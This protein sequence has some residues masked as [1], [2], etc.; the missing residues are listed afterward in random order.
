MNKGIL[1]FSIQLAEELTHARRYDTAKSYGCSVRSLL[2]FTGNKELK[3]SDLNQTML[4]EYRQYLSTMGRTRNSILMNLR[5]LRTICQRAADQL[6]INLSGDLFTGLFV[7]EGK[8]ERRSD[9]SR[10]IARLAKLDLGNRP[11][12]LGF[13]RDLFLLSFHLGG[14]SFTDLAHLRKTDVCGGEIR[15][16]CSKL[17]K[18][19][20]VALDPSAL[21]IIDR[22]SQHTIDSPYVLP[23]LDGNEEE[24]DFRY[25]NA[26]CWY[27]RS[28]DR[29]TQMLMLKHNIASYLSR[30][31]GSEAV[32]EEGTTKYV[33]S[34]ND[35]ILGRINRKVIS[36]IDLT[37]EEE[38]EGM[39]IR[40]TGKHSSRIASREPDA[41]PY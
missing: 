37:K 41:N 23:I 10:I 17:K 40:K 36:Y 20:N 39:K 16:R 14:I 31:S 38:S 25:Q 27:N 9:A 22:Y 29:L 8:A 33:A 21:S 6:N 13:A 34:H 32:S 2:K 5:I 26:V 24:K 1:I 18:E 11:N 35:N 28:L 15:Y 7:E 30:Y 19:M 12:S 4:K 3:F